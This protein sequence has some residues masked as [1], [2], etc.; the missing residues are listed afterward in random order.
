[1]TTVE[2]EPIS[3]LELTSLNKDAQTPS[4]T[5]SP[6]L[7]DVLNQE[8]PENGVIA[9]Q[10]VASVIRIYESQ[11]HPSSSNQFFKILMHSPNVKQAKAVFDTIV[12]WE[13]SSGHS[14]IDGIV[15]NPD[16]DM[17]LKKWILDMLDFGF[18]SMLKQKILGIIPDIFKTNKFLT[19]V[20]FVKAAF[21][22]VMFYWDIFKDFATYAIFNHMSTNIL[23]I[24]F[25][26]TITCF[27]ILIHPF[28]VGQV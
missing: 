12:N 6:T 10:D 19:I 9:P 16:T 26:I 13:K 14:T 3:D 1:M 24:F 15:K 8:I 25:H 2:T 23:V 20:S 5:F 4:L 7:V 28:S 21:Q 17:E 11:Y 18:F 22:T 27:T